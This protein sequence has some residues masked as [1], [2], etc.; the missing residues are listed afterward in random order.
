M[1]K[2]IIELSIGLVNLRGNFT[3]NWRLNNHIDSSK[4]RVYLL[5]FYE[6]ISPCKELLTYNTPINNNDIRLT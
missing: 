4:K 5:N 6:K 2:F 1:K 3:I